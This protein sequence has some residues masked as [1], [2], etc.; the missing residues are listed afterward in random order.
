MRKKKILLVCAGG[1][2]TSLFVHAMQLLITEEQALEV[3]CCDIESSMIEIY[4]CDVVLLAPQVNYS[5]D[6]LEQ[7]A[8]TLHIPFGMMDKE[9]YSSFDGSAALIFARELLHQYQHE[10]VFQIDMIHGMNGGAIGSLLKM[11]IERKCQEIG[12][13]VQVNSLTSS[14]FIPQ[15]CHA[16]VVLIEP[17][18]AF[19][20]QEYRSFLN[21][22]TTALGVIDRSMLLHFDGGV[23]L[24]YAF[25][26]YD[27]LCMQRKETYIKQEMEDNKL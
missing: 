13:H 22:Y 2:S 19:L 15:K 10:A 17:Q 18:V 4:D 3:R 21:P 20:Q 14:Q 26:L 8:N 16:H 1:M 25:A 6:A 5:K 23:I 7:I 24:N 12:L 9:M 11:A 27:A